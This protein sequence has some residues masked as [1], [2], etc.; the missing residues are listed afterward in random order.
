MKKR[1]V[2]ITVLTQLPVVIQIYY[3]CMYV[4]KHEVLLQISIF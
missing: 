1:Q 2:N 4:K 3:V